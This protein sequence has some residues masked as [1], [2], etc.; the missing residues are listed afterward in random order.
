MA[1][2]CAGESPKTYDPERSAAALEGVGWVV[3]Q[4]APPPT[5]AGGGRPLAYLETTAPDRRR[6]DLQFLETPE[7]ATAELAARRRQTPAFAGA[8]VGNVVV[9]PAGERG[10]EIPDADLGLLRNRLATS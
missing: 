6:I 8:T 10:D 4:L 9:I 1:T 3:S 2:G 7:A 5:T